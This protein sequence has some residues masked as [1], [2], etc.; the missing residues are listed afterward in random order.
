MVIKC[1][2]SCKNILN[3]FIHIKII[4]PDCLYQAVSSGICSG[5]GLGVVKQP[6]T[7]VC[8]KW[9]DIGFCPVVRDRDLPVSHKH[10]QVLSLVEAV[11][12]GFFQFL[13]CS[14]HGRRKY[15]QPTT[16]KHPE[17]SEKVLDAVSAAPAAA[18][19]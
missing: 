9:T 2:H 14:I 12:Q 11:G 7:A 1:R 4:C 3:V 13:I 15:F 17:L 5:S 6:D 16:R 18:Y 19:L 10:F 8:C